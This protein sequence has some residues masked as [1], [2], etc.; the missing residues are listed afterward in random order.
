MYCQIKIVHNAPYINIATIYDMSLEEQLEAQDKFKQVNPS[1][2][3][4][5]DNFSEELFGKL[6]KFLQD[7][8][9]KSPEY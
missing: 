3:F 7:K 5:L 2:L 8:I 4:D 6:P 9:L 1:M